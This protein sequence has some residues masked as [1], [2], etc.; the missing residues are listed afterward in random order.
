MK[1]SCQLQYIMMGGGCFDVKEYQGMGES[2]RVFFLIGQTYTPPLKGKNQKMR[3]SEYLF[4]SP[5]QS[6]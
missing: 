1:Q 4:V 6:L 2:V 3:H 5:S